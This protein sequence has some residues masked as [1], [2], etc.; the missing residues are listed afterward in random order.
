MPTL[1]AS[2]SETNKDD[3]ADFYT[4]NWRGQ[5]F[6]TPDDGVTYTITSVK[7]Y[8]S[9]IGTNGCGNFNVK[10]YSHSGTYGTS[11]VPGSLLA[12]SDTANGSNFTANP[13][14]TLYEIA[15]SGAQQVELDP[16]TA[17]VLT[18]ETSTGDIDNRCFW[19]RDGSSPSY[20]GN[21][22]YTPSYPSWTA[23]ADVDKCFY[24]YGQGPAGPAHLKT[25]NGIAKAN[26]KTINGKAI[27]NVKT[28]NG[29][30]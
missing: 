13:T 12:T 28:I 10:L 29:I 25:W 20:G 8:G 1:L 14:F 15:F 5:S 24:V 4:S 11:S 19:G 3:A 16:N 26:I 21:G 30:S 2:Y 23:Q 27:A 22:M 7:I 9:R 17:Y 18:V 6:K